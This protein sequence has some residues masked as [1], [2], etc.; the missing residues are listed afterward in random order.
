MTTHFDLRFALVASCA[1]ASAGLAAVACSSKD[2]STT[3][4]TGDG[5]TTSSS[6]SSGATGNVPAG[7]LELVVN[8]MAAVGASEWI[9]IANKGSAAFD[10]S[11]YQLADSDKTTGE[12]KTK[13][14]MKFPAGTSI[15]A[16][17]KV[18]V[19]TSKKDQ[20]V[21]PHPKAECLANGPD[22][23]FY[24]G[25]GLSSANGEQVHLL[26]KD[27]AVIASTAYPRNVGVDADAGQT[28]CRLPDMTGEFATCKG[29]PG[30]ANAGP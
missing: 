29:T 23:C 8:E 6:G 12:P 5:G 3:T 9:E 28:A 13:D 27:G 1:L 11:D 30:A 24:A 7:A 17:G 16:G 21:G 19:L 20:P 15:A 26:G 10:L 25:W 22:T 4:T 14:A 2:E 18:L